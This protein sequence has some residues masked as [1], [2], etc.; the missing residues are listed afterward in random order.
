MAGQIGNR[1]DTHGTRDV[2]RDTPWSIGRGGD[3]G[4]DIDF[5]KIIHFLL[6]LK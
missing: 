3:T 2:F 4:I 5:W 1:H 6:C